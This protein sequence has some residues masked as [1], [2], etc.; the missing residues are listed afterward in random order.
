VPEALLEEVTDIIASPGLSLDLPFFKKARE[1]G[2]AIYG[3]IECLAREIK[4][5]VVAITGTNGKSTVTTLV[6]LMAQEAGLNVAVAG[7]IGAPVLDRLAEHQSYDLWVLELSSFQLDLTHSLAPVAAMI[8]N[9]SPDHL[10]RHHTLEAYIQAKQ[11]VYHQAQT[12]LYNRNDRATQPDTRYETSGQNRSYGN[13][14]PTSAQDWGLIHKEG[15]IYLAQGTQCIF[16]VDALLIKGVH[17]WHN[18]LAACA[19]ADAAGIPI[20]AMVRV[21]S[22]FAGLEHRC[23]WLRTLDGVEWVNDS[24]GTNIGATVSAING[25]GGS[26]QGKIVLIA[27]GQGKG[28]DFH[29]LAQSVADFV[30]S[31]VLIGEDADQMEVALSEVVPVSRATSLDNAVVIA[32]KHAKPGD[33][34]LLSPACASLDMFRDYNHRGEVFAS[35]VMGL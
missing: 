26:M 10:D 31:L 22:S 5:P 7:N 18:A 29:E 28:A 8:L 25:I 13:E 34:V 16:S 24:K 33:V 23:Q 12:R 21:L 20:D 4:T 30:R 6:G 14:A 15:Q 2:I 3:D 32:K 19:L 1:A 9:V 35:I 17:N 11:R 27:G